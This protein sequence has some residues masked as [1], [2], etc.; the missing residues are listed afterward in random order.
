LKEGLKSREKADKNVFFS[1]SEVHTRNFLLFRVE[2]GI[3]QENWGAFV[4]SFSPVAEGL[5][6]LCFRI[7]STG[8]PAWTRRY[9]IFGTIPHHRYAGWTHSNSPVNK[10]SL[11]RNRGDEEQENGTG[12]SGFE[13]ILWGKAG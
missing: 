7:R 3:V 8:C 6:A 4:N 5:Y 12:G 11:E 2:R 1:E 9:P 10:T 13:K